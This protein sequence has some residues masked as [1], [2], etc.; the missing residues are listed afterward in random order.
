MTASQERQAPFDIFIIGGGVNGCGVARDAAGRGY[1]VG[2]AERGDLAEGTSSKSTGLIHGGLRYLETHDFRLV[3]EALT[4]REIL[5]GI[6]PHLV[7]PLRFVLPV[8]SGMRPAWLL[9]LGL[10]LY[11]HIGGRKRLPPTV[12]LDLR[13][14]VA[15]RAL[16]TQ[17]T[18]AF[19][20]SDCRV[21]DARLV[22]LNARDAAD[23]GADVMTRTE[24]LS[25]EAAEGLWRVNLRDRATG[26]QSEI[27]ARLLVNAAG[28]WADE[29]IAKVAGRPEDPRLRLVRGSHIVVR[30]LFEHDRAY[31]FQTPDRR[32]VFAIPYCEEFTVIGA[33]RRRSCRAPGPVA[34]TPEET[35][36]L[37]RAAN[38][39]FRRQIAPPDV[40]WSWSGL[41]PL[42]DDHAAS[43]R[44]ATREH[45][46]EQE[47]I[48]GA[49]LI[50]LF[51]GKITSYRRLSDEVLQ[52]A[53]SAIGARGKPWTAQAALPGGDIPGGDLDA[54]TRELAGEKPFLGPALARRLARSY[55]TL[56]RRFLGDASRMQDLG[57]DFGGGMTKAEVDYLIASEWARSPEDILWRRSKLGLTGPASLAEALAAYFG[58]KAVETAQ[59]GSQR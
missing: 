38:A 41:R 46:M 17:F 43:A 47:L 19:E 52:C 24:V 40:V 16:Q 31:L 44:E 14:D 2:L 30:K 5:W 22:V 34:I 33:D 42:F 45:V 1:R 6:A 32:V 53:G 25:A 18:R 21:D 23:R 35:E 8:Q 20:Y 13:S 28:P 56:C 27:G 55:G 29:V 36:Y 51:G 4:E 58:K 10:F 37:C 11:D 48:E 7:G 50:S 15:G 9:R 54:F 49:P 3:R 26:V 59:I 39:H 12:T 57:G